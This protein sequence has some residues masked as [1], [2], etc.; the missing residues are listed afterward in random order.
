MKNS[1]KTKILFIHPDLRNPGGIE[2]Y[3]LK[4]IKH[5]RL[6]VDQFVVGKR[7]G[8]AGN[9][10]R[11]LRTWSDI[12]RF[13]ACL[14]REQPDVVVGN[15]SL[16]FKGLLRDG[17]LLYLA[18]RRRKHTVLFIRGWYRR[19]EQRINRFG[20]GFFRLLLRRV[21]AFIVLSAENAEKLRRW[22]FTQPIHREVTILD[23][24]A[25]CGFDLEAT[26]QTRRQAPQ[27][28]ILF[29]AR[30]LRQKGIHLT[31]EA[32]AL[33]QQR[34]PEVE[35]IIAGEGPE[36]PA[37][38]ETAER[39]G[40]RNC[41]FVGYVRGEDKAETFRSAHLYCLP[42]DTE[43]MPNSVVEAMAWGLPVVTRPVGGLADFFRDGQHG[44]CTASKEAAEFARLMERL[45]VDWRLYEEIARRNHQYALENFLASQAAKRLEAIFLGISGKA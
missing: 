31:I 44:F 35:L 27:K 29:L 11:L 43:G 39:V 32:V 1:T 16:D 28:R 5:M 41:R 36:L 12:R 21:D 15:P 37:A 13:R 9:G 3:Y 20:I 22:G 34:L 30:L 2:N 26:L 14:K 17:F 19:F 38:R 40:L 8:E 42:S 4:L 18:G 23:D 7:R 25:L 6:P 10:A 33:L 45:L 24:E